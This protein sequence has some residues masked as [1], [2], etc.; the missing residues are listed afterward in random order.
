MDLEGI[1]EEFARSR[2]PLLESRGNDC[3]SIKDRNKDAEGCKSFQSLDCHE[4]NEGKLTFGLCEL[5]FI[6][7]SAES[8][9]EL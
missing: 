8:F 3:W 5:S 7:P 9:V 1:S 2:R 6:Y 4:A